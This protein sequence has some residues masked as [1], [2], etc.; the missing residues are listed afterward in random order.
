[1]KFQLIDDKHTEVFFYRNQKGETIPFPT[2]NSDI[3]RG[4]GTK[5]AK[6]AL[7]QIIEK[8]VDELEDRTHVAF[9]GPPIP[10]YMIKCYCGHTINVGRDEVGYYI[11]GADYIIFP[12]GD[13]PLARERDVIPSDP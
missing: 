4:L 10:P 13:K 9:M 7:R 6:E 1:M 2:S 8:G 3:V 12:P 11:E 5:E